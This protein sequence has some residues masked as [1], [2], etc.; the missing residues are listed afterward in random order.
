MVIADRVFEH[1]QQASQVRLV[2]YE[3]PAGLSPVDGMP[4]EGGF[5]VTEEWRGVG[6][7]VKTLGFSTDRSSALERLEQRAKQLQ[8]QRYQPVAPAA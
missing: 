5:L 1:P 7:V 3:R 2:V 4:D 8:L 6:K